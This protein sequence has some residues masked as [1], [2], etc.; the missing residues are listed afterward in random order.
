[1]KFPD[2]FTLGIFLDVNEPRV[3]QLAVRF[4]AARPCVVLRIAAKKCKVDPGLQT[5]KVFDEKKDLCLTFL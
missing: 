4:F 5:H 1:M 2:V 3:R